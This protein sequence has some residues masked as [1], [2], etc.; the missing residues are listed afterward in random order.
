[1]L[2]AGTRVPLGRLAVLL[3][4]LLLAFTQVRHQSWFAIVGA[5]LVPPLFATKAVPARRL[6]PLGLAAVAAVAVRLALPA[7]PPDNVANPRALIAAVPAALRAQP[8]FNEYSFGGPLILAGIRPYVD[9][10]SELYGDAFMNDYVAILGGDLARFD[11][12][13]A[14][15]NIRWAMLPANSTLAALLVKSGW[16]RVYAD[17]V[18]VILARPE[19]R[20]A[21][22]APR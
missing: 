5:V 4:M 22:A 11:R 21:S 15:Y 13:A 2:W 14:R 20:G 19:A 18:G 3:A 9:G 7:T 12:A 10:R 16:R 1:M 17:K 8:V 6:L